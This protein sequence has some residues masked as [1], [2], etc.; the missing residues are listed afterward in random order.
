MTA[1]I[2]AQLEKVD[3]VEL[4]DEAPEGVKPTFAPFYRDEIALLIRTARGLRDRHKY[5]IAPLPDGEG[6]GIY[7]KQG[8]AR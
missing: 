3:G 2:K 5:C 7:A 6:L 4:L 8:G 1:D